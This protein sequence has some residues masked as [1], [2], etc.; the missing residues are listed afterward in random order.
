MGQ[1]I[2]V[3]IGILRILRPSKKNRHRKCAKA[4]KNIEMLQITQRGVE[5]EAEKNPKEKAN[6][7]QSGGAK[8]YKKLQYRKKQSFERQSENHNGGDG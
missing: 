2:Y 4:K 6:Q 7:E 5:K 8:N 3:H 1:K